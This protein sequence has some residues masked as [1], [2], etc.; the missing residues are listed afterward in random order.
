MTCKIITFQKFMCVCIYIYIIDMKIMHS[1][2]TPPLKKPPKYQIDR[3][4]TQLKS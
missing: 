2:P 3:N 4:P 1:F